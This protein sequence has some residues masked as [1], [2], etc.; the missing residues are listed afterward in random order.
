MCRA[1]SCD[2]AREGKVLT[3]DFERI[4]LEPSIQTYSAMILPFC[5][6]ARYFWSWT[7]YVSTLR[8]RDGQVIQ[9]TPAAL[10]I[11]DDP[12]CGKSKQWVLVMPMG[13]LAARETYHSCGVC[14]EVDEREVTGLYVAI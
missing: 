13:V 11:I 9:L 6:R 14:V 7:R 5:P 2:R 12:A 1:V 3:L 10:E 8:Q 4:P